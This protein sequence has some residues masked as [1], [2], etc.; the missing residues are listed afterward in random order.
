M[1]VGAPRASARP[2]TILAG[3][4]LCLAAA[5]AAQDAATLDLSPRYAVGDRQ[6]TQARVDLLLKLRLRAPT[7]NID[8]TSEQEQVIVR[9][10]KDTL[11][12]VADGKVAE[13]ERQFVEAWDGER[14]P[15]A[16]NLSRELSPL[17]QR[18]ITVGLD[19]EGKR[20]VQPVGDPPILEE[21]LEDEL[22]TERWES[23]LPKDPVAVGATWTIEGDRLRRAL[24]KGLGASPEGKIACRFAEVREVA[25]DEGAPPA[26]YAVVV[27]DVDAAGQHGTEEDAPRMRTTLHGEVLFSLDARKVAKVDLEGEA[28]LRQTRRDGEVV[29]DLDGRGPITI[30]KR[31]WFPERPRGKPA[32]PPGLPG[33]PPRPGR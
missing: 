30:R 6:E 18:R 13:V 19:A 2:G 1:I 3:L 7:A 4:A 14:L 21:V 22:H 26:R 5:A 33:E 8:R 10:H 24:G 20:K 25:L 27:V 15:G 31:T 17:H 28:R 29:V 11:V 23:V 16:A 32:P 12:R 9:H